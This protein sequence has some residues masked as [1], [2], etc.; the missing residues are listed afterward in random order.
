MDF[1]KTTKKTSEVPDRAVRE[2]RQPVKRSS[3][4]L[5]SVVLVVLLFT[6]TGIA[7]IMTKK[8]QDLKK[9][10]QS[11]SQKQQES[12]L[13]KVGA[14]MD[15]PKDE[16]PSIATVSDKEKLKEQAFFKSA[17]N[18]DTL[19]IYTNAKKA[20]LYRESTNKIVEVAPIAIDTTQAGTTA[21]ASTESES[22]QPKSPDTNKKGQ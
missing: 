13:S 22:A 1:V 5:L 10:P 17:E 9:N 7:G 21:G 14:L 15:L 11:I 3:P 6:A 16:Q 8:Y 19:L 4:K 2:D 20:V 18:G 12:L